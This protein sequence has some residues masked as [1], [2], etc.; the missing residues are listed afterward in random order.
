MVLRGDS[1]TRAGNPQPSGANSGRGPATGMELR[2][3]AGAAQRG[4]LCTE[5]WQA[6][7]GPSVWAHVGECSVGQQVC[8][9]MVDEGAGA[10]EGTLTTM[11][12]S[13][14]RLMGRGG[15]TAKGESLK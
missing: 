13:M 9:E 3:Q 10:K 7:L 8:R 2:K 15:G 5:R 14:H 1:R 4:R 6:F 12:G 11:A